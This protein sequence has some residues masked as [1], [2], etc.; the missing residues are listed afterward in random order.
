MSYSELGMRL[1]TEILCP[2]FTSSETFF[3]KVA[4]ILVG[5]VAG[6]V[7][8]PKVD[9]KLL[10]NFLLRP[11]RGLWGGVLGNT[12]SKVE[13]IGVLALTGMKPS[14]LMGGVSGGD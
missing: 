8:S 13:C 6:G 4:F 9:L 3:A 12:C 14:L 10:E 5:G 2:E 1:T 11:K 7:A